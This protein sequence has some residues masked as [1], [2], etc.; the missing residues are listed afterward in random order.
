VGDF[1]DEGFEVVLSKLHWELVAFLVLT[2]QDQQIRCPSF[3]FE[4]SACRIELVEGI[5]AVL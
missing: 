1:V 2:I 5:V 4:S 3:L